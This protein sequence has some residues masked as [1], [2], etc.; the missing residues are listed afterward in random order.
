MTSAI[1]YAPKQ[2]GLTKAETDQGP[3]IPPS[4]NTGSKKGT[5]TSSM[6]EDMGAW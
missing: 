4:P 1:S 6:A 5:A 3:N 2:S